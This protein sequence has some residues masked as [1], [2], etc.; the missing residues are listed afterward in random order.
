MN[1]SNIVDNCTNNELFLDFIF[2]KIWE[3]CIHHHSTTVYFHFL[4]GNQK[5]IL[6]ENKKTISFR[7]SQLNEEQLY[8][9]RILLFSYGSGL[10]S[11]MY[12][13]ICRKVHDT[14]FTLGQIQKTIRQARDILDNQRVEITPDLMNQLLSEREHNDH[15]APFIPT[16]P[17]DSLKSGD[18]YLKSVD[19]NHRR[20]YE[21]YIAT[22][23]NEKITVEHIQQVYVCFSLISIEIYLF[24]LIE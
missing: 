7:F 20:F 11:T 17:K 22:D 12:S 21:K 19:K 15:R 1:L 14:R 10:A 8:G 9:R 6:V 5:K 24:F 23:K 18:I 4:A 3:I 16:Q 2:L 13:M